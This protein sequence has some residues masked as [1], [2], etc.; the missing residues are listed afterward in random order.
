MDVRPSIGGAWY[1]RDPQRLAQSLESF[2]AHADE[3]PLLGKLWGVV[4]PHAGHRYSG[5]VAAHAFR[6]LRGLRPELIV[7]VSPFHS[8][9]R[10]PLLTTGHEAYETPLGLIEVDR[11]ALESLNHALRNRLGIGLTPIRND[12]EHSLEVELPFLQKVLEDFR[13]LPVMISDQSAAVAEVLGHALAE[14]LSQHQAILAASSD[15]SHFYPQE[16]ARELDME[17]LR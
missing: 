4:V 13:L 14:S 2:L 5:Q 9:T 16:T 11:Q 1:P 6:C 15:L 12:P 17:L 10:K 7:V 8:P 3:E